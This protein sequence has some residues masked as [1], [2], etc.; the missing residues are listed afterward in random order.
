M[1]AAQFVGFDDRELTLFPDRI[2]EQLIQF[3]A[4]HRGEENTSANICL[5]RGLSKTPFKNG[6]PPKR[7]N[8]GARKAE[9][10]RIFLYLFSLKI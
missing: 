2:Q 5:R 9:I 3:E 1:D 7:K 10:N 8:V 6:I 4:V